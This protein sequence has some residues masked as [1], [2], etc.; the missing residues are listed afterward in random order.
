M[1]LKMTI[2]LK[3]MLTI[4]VDPE[5]YPIPSDDKIDEEMKDY[6]SDLIHEI[7]GVTLKH[8]KILQERKQNE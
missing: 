8:I 5:E 4:H 1:L 6:I 3:V 7:D 2:R